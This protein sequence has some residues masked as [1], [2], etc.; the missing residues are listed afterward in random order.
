MIALLC[1]GLHQNVTEYFQ[2]WIMGDAINRVSIS[3]LFLSVFHK[4]L[5]GSSTNMALKNNLI[6]TILLF[7][8]LN[9]NLRVFVSILIRFYSWREVLHIVL[10]QKHSFAFFGF[11]IESYPSVDFQKSYVNNTYVNISKY[12][13][14][15]NSIM[16]H[17]WMHNISRASYRL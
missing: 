17:H 10:F 2:Y 3:G 7:R 6:L 15:I 14:S 16:C 8:M 12:A 5:K 1:D 9:F 13:R 11:M 4:F